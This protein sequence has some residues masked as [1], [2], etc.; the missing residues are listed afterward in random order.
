MTELN[1]H[2]LTLIGV[3][4]LALGTLA[5]VG[6]AGLARLFL[7]YVP[8]VSKAWYMG[9]DDAYKALEQ[10]RRTHEHTK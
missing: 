3:I 8:L 4:C 9:R 7:E 5:C 10:R 1:I 2:Q 6:V